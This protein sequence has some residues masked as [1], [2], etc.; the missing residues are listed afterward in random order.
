MHRQEPRGKGAIARAGGA[1]GDKKFTSVEGAEKRKSAPR[2][3]AGEGGSAS[4][5][6]GTYPWGNAV[7]IGKNNCEGKE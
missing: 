3:M 2:H 1:T 6:K 4:K 7:E 5:Q